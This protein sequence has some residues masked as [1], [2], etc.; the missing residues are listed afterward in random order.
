MNAS[1]H[2]A[3]P[4]K[5]RGIGPSRPIKLDQQQQR[6]PEKAARAR[7]R[8]IADGSGWPRISL[9]CATYIHAGLSCQV[10]RVE[11]PSVVRQRWSGSRQGR[12]LEM[13]S[14]AFFFLFF[15]VWKVTLFWLLVGGIL[16]FWVSWHI[17]AASYAF[18]IFQKYSESVASTIF[19]EE[20]RFQIFKRSTSTYLKNVV[21]IRVSNMKKLCACWVYLKNTYIFVTI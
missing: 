9:S 18:K 5:T 10:V 8:R 2:L 6:Q 13:L 19:S 14:V 20:Y 1:K 17:R 4:N 11:I 15:F 12:A 3:H 21:D 7:N 16:I